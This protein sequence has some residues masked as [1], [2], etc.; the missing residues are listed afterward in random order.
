MHR[1]RTVGL[2]VWS[3]ALWSSVAR[4][5]EPASPTPSAASPA[6][7]DNREP[8][9]LGDGVESDVPAK[10]G[11]SGAFGIEPEN[12]QN[13]VMVL[14]RSEGTLSGAVSVTLAGAS[15]T[16]SVE[17]N[18][19]GTAPDVRAG[20]GI[21]AGV[22]DAAPQSGRVALKTGS[23]TLDGNRVEWAEDDRARELQL[24]IVDGVLKAEATVHQGVAAVATPNGDPMGKPVPV[25]AG[26][27]GSAP[28]PAG[29]M[30]EAPRTAVSAGPTP[31][32]AAGPA[33][34]PAAAR[35]VQ[36]GAVDARAGAA[37]AERGVG[38]WGVVPGVLAL[39][40][41]IGALAVALRAW[42]TGKGRA[43]AGEPSPS[44]PLPTRMSE[45]GLLGPGT[46]S[47][48]AGVS[49]W[50]GP[51]A[52][53]RPLL[54]HVARGRPVVVATGEAVSMPAVFGGPVFHVASLDPATV[55]RAVEAVHQR[56]CLSVGVVV[57][58]GK[59][60]DKAYADAL[61]QALPVDVGAVV[62]GRSLESGCPVVVLSPAPGG[63][64]VSVDGALLRTVRST[65]RGFEWD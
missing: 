1:R 50:T 61:R 46:P 36:S 3:L 40:F 45:P 31:G 37:V 33:S 32:V 20:D 42:S 64:G 62:W 38:G 12:E 43:G 49:V 25:A 15:Q 27:A 56:G 48:S 28:A 35:P 17:M 29:D 23:G 52:V 54:A 2:V 51:Q 39:L 26:E 59:P 11:P 57:L 30:G 24:R 6:S 10:P 7:D 55:A 65:T 41:A 19:Q 63:A 4:A 47:A 44:L 58:A 21:W 5:Q 13:G 60:V 18:D 9:P 53:L 34:G 14:L 8:P 16:V 22:V